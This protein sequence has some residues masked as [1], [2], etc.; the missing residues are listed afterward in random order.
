MPSFVEYKDAVWFDD[1]DGWLDR[2][3]TDQIARLR[4]HI[5]LIITMRGDALKAKEAEL[6]RE[7]AAQRAAMKALGLKK[8]Y[9]PR[10]K[11][12]ESD[13]PADQVKE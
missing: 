12:S 2:A 1:L 4:E 5:D 3:E 11:P 6:K 10:K 8:K 7:K 9:K 13:T